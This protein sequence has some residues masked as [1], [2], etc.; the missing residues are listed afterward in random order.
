MFEC[1][2]T[3]VSHHAIVQVFDEH[4]FDTVSLEVV[5]SVSFATKPAVSFPARRSPMR[6]AQDA[7]LATVRDIS[8]APSARRRVEA[9]RGDDPSFL[10]VPAAPRR[11]VRSSR[12]GIVV[13]TLA[14][15]VLSIGAGALGLALQPAV[16]DGPTVVK[17]AV[18][19]DSVWSLAQGVKSERPLEEIVSDIERLNDL[20]GALQ[21]GQR[22]VV[23][24]R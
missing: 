24:V 17:A 14:T 18:S 19:G 4:V 11:S 22:V 13:G 3:F 6:V 8:S 23:P 12:R 9:Q 1:A 7:P 2:S 10:R 15:L 16:Y 5:M 21:P 20:S